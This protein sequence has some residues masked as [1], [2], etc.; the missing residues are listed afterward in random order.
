M[1]AFVNKPGSK[2]EEFNAIP[3]SDDPN[4]YRTAQ[5]YIQALLKQYPDDVK[6]LVTCPE[7]I[8]K[9]SWIYSSFRQFL[10]EINYFA[11]EHRFVSTAENESKM[12]FT[13]NGQQVECLSAA[14]NPPQMVP[15]IDYITETVDMATQMILKAD[16]FP[17]GIITDMGLKQ[18][19]T[20]MRRLYRVFAF[21]YICHREVFDE[22]EAKNHLCERFTMFARLYGLLQPTDIFIPDSYF[23]KTPAQAE[24]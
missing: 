14:K 10:Q 18:I 1:K 20:Y 22:L 2:K 8:D 6:K 19:Q 9:G 16:L 21:S 3:F 12:V 15:A 23:S 13:I 4:E 5:Y 7:S 17:G 24:A 11:Y